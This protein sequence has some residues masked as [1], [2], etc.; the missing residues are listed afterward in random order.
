MHLELHELLKFPLFMF[1][2][3]FN[4]NNGVNP[5]AIKIVSIKFLLTISNSRLD[6]PW[7][8]FYTLFTLLF[9]SFENNPKIN[10]SCVEWKLLPQLLKDISTIISNY[11][12]IFENFH[13]MST[14]N[15]FFAI[16]LLRSGRN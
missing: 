10:N 6:F 1:S 2:H 12:K 4:V 3:K 15:S 11:V 13:L 16:P 5:K 7:N 14:T 9:L 8:N